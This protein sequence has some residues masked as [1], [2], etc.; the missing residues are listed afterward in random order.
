MTGTAI[1]GIA[2]LFATSSMGGR[3]ASAGKVCHDETCKPR[4]S[5]RAFACKTLKA[6]H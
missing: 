4:A 1:V 6:K 5:A 2:E 3:S